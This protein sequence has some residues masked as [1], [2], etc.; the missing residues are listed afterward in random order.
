[1]QIVE[2]P[3][4][5]IA[6]YSLVTATAAS[7]LP[8]PT[9]ALGSDWEGAIHT[10]ISRQARR[11][12]EHPAVLDS[13]GAWTYQE[14]DARSNQ[15]AHYLRAHGIRAQDVVAIYGHRSVSLVWALLGVLKAGAAFT[16][17]DPAY[18][19]LRLIDYVQLAKPRGW[20]QVEA[21]GRLPGSLEEFVARASR[22]VC[23][24]VLPPCATDAAHNLLKDYSTGDAGVTVGPD[25]LACV[26]FTSGSTGKPKGI[27]GKH[28]PLSHFMPWQSQT[29][30]LDGSDRYSMLS[31]LS[32]DPLQRDI[33][34]SLWLGAT[35]CIPTPEELYT[36]GRLAGWMREQKISVAHLTPAMIQMLTQTQAGEEIRSL[37]Y[38]FIVGDVLT[39][40]DVSRLQRLAPWVTCVNLYGATET[41]R[42]IGYYVVP[43]ALSQPDEELLEERQKQVL[44]L[45]RGVEDVQLLILNTSRQLAGIGEVGEI[46]VRSPHLAGGYVGDD[47]LTEECFPVNPFTAAASDRLYKTGDLGRYL[48]DGNVEFLGRGDFQVKIRGFRVEPGEIEAALGRHPAVQQAVVLAREDSPGASKTP[49]W[50][51]RLVAYVVFNQ[52]QAPV[53]GELRRFLRERLPVYMVPAAFVFLECLP[54]TPN[55]KV[56]RNKLPAPDMTRLALEEAFVAPQT[57]VEGTLA[58]IWAEV[59]GLERVGVHNNFFDLGGHS[60]HLIQVHNRLREAFDKDLPVIK[61]FEYP[62]IHSLAE[63]LSQ[64]QDHYPALQQSADRGTA[65]I[66][67]RLEQRDL[68]E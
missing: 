18:P 39:K 25:D 46:Y 49:P 9:Q 56:D 20:L 53:V 43:P 19:A 15:L 17:L 32:H 13:Q 23:R 16:I 31:G 12:P 37:R 67:A 45:G 55:R 14:L 29:F 61:M 60:L 38:A 28:G 22:L 42:A 44:P 11:V 40:Q 24:L 64:E 47:A 27:M 35:L 4:E 52:G 65:R 51:K 21:A 62:T 2:Q 1:L 8:D 30:G 33:F 66:A 50:D 6:R 41:Q 34:T 26:T 68:R 7:V 59:L 63:Y 3:G 57:P 10:Q 54:L 58:H 5:H 36:P 48:P